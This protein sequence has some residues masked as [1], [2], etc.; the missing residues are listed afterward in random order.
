MKESRV[1]QYNGYARWAKTSCLSEFILLKRGTICVELSLYESKFFM[2]HELVLPS[3]K[4]VWI[5]TDIKQKS[6]WTVLG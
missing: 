4:I 2:H 3:G 1:I 5:D 6:N